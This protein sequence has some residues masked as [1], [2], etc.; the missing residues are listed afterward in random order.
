MSKK[1]WKVRQEDINKLK[2]RLHGHVNMIVDE[3]FTEVEHKER[4]RKYKRSLQL[5]DR[6]YISETD[7]KILQM[8]SDEAFEG[9]LVGFKKDMR[10]FPPYIATVEWDSGERTVIGLGW[11]KK[12][13]DSKS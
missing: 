3:L 6:V 2:E 1:I 8:K 7:R 4:C 12:K 9:K 13:E 5:G 10:S 11:L